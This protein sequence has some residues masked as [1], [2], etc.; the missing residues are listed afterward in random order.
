MEPRISGLE[1]VKEPTAHEGLAPE[2]VSEHPRQ[3]PTRMGVEEDWRKKSWPNSLLGKEETQQSHGDYNPTTRY[4]R[5]VIH[6]KP[7]KEP[8]SRLTTTI[9]ESGPR[10][11]RFVPLL[12]QGLHARS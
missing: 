10:A 4:P 3:I 12:L 11:A 8:N 6:V 9:R 2:Q 7:V 1:P 5:A